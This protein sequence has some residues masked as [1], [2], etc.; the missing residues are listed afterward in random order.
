[1]INLISDFRTL[2]ASL[3]DL[4]LILDPNFNIIEVSRA[5]LKATLVQ[6]EN[7]L[8]RNVF[9]VFP[10]NPDDPTA[11]GVANLSASLK[12]VLQNKTFDAMAIQKYDIRRP[13]A[14]GGGFEER[15]WK[16]VNTAVL[17]K[18]NKVKYIIHRVE[19]VTEF[20]Q[21]KKMGSEQQEAIRALSTPILQL[22]EKLLLLPLIG[23]IDTVRVQQI[24][25]KLLHTIQLKRAR[26][27]VVD[28]TGV[29]MMDAKAANY[30]IQTL[31][32]M[33]L[34]G[35]S[36]I[37]TGLSNEVA[38]M[39]INGGVDFSKLTTMG[40]LQSGVEQAMALL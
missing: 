21:L 37:V 7:I 31:E 32:A 24:I 20:V 33:R 28:V 4:Y 8:G 6:R 9:D 26:A 3:P 30:L 18:N 27:V 14:E 15:F 22:G 40:D 34:M 17:G 25:E 13:E 36:L 5:Y 29:P 23:I 35:A 1:M 38:N 2:F 16:P 10:D 39:W 11:T 12:R 19:D